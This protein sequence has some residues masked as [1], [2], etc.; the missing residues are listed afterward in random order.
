[1]HLAWNPRK[2]VLTLIIISNTFKIFADVH[3]SG[4]A[5]LPGLT[6]PAGLQGFKGQPG[7]AGRSRPGITG[8]MGAKGFPGIPGDAGLDGTP[9]TT[10][11]AGLPGLP[12]QKVGLN[13]G[14]P[15]LVAYVQIT[16]TFF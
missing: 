10:G 4:A 12:G 13:A 16:A 2:A 11:D 1:L 9:G 8:P 3:F 15:F 5:G 14:V 6:G 7:I